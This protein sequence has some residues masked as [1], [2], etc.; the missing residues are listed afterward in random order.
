MEASRQSWPTASGNHV[1]TEMVRELTLCKRS[2]AAERRKQK[3]SEESQGAEKGRER[4]S[5]K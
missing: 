5:G 3:T 1:S 2:S 4:D